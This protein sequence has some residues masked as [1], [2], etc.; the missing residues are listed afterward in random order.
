MNSCLVTT[1]VFLLCFS[2]GSLCSLTSATT[3]W[4]P[5]LST[6]FKGTPV[7]LVGCQADRRGL[8]SDKKY[9]VSSERA[10]AYSRQCGAVMYVETSAKDSDRSFSAAFELAALTCLGH[11]SSLITSSPIAI[12]NTKTKSSPRIS[13]SQ[14]RC[15]IQTY[16]L[17]MNCFSP[18]P[19]YETLP[20]TLGC[21]SVSQSSISLIS[22]SST[23]SS[24]RSDSSVISTNKTNF[25][26]RRVGK[27]V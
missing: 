2:I 27:K 19:L 11:Y 13:T 7:I 20:L 22:K 6:L 3:S 14:K 10:L 17:K 21:K 18:S 9:L 23:L 12:T 26:T 4:M 15:N 16:N 8:S 5:A 1:D 24:I 25:V